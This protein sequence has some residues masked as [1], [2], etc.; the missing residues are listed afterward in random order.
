MA[1]FAGD[2]GGGGGGGGGGEGWLSSLSAADIAWGLNTVR[3]R[4]FLGKYPEGAAL[5][6]LQGMPPSFFS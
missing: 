2:D 6:P 5:P 4:S 3:S 1:A